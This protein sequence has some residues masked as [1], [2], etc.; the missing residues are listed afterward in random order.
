MTTLQHRVTSLKTAC[1]L[2]LTAVVPFL[3]GLVVYAVIGLLMMAENQ[4]SGY[5]NAFL[6]YT[7]LMGPATVILLLGPLGGAAGAFF[8]RFILKY[9][10][11]ASEELSV[12]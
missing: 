6:N 12:V 4:F 1:A 10:K 8:H 9:G 2:G 5:E 7:R 3:I 11:S